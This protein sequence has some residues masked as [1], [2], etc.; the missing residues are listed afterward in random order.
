MMKIEGA[1]TVM[2]LIF[3]MLIIGNPIAYFVMKGKDAHDAKEG[4]AL[5]QSV[6]CLFYLV[7]CVCFI[8][9]MLWLFRGY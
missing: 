1:S 2:L 5:L 3:A 9:A 7:V 4:S 8:P 6:G